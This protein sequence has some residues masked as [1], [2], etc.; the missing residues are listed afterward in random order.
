MTRRNRQDY[1]TKNRRSPNWYLNFRIP[2]THQHVSEFEGRRVYQISTQTSDYKRA[3]NYRDAFFTVFKLFGYGT[4]E[5][6]SETQQDHF[7]GVEG[8]TLY[9]DIDIIK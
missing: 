8:L 1:L 2:E 7:S 6:T 9:D 4:D 5:S 3:C